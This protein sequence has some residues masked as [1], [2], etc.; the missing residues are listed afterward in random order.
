LSV[1]GN[2]DLA[3]GTLLAEIN[4]V[5]QGTTYDWLPVNGVVTIGPNSKLTLIFGAAAGNG[6]AYDVV[7]AGILSGTFALNNISFSNT[8]SGNVTGITV[9]YPGGTIV[10]ITIASPLPIELV[11]FQAI[12]EGEQVRLTWQTASEINNEGF[13]VERSLDIIGWEEIGFV[14]GKG[15]TTAVQNYSFLDEKPATS[16][17]YYRLRQ[18]DFDGKE[19]LSKIVSIDL[20]HLQ[21]L[22]IQVFPNP[23]KA[24]GELTLFLPDV[25]RAVLQG[26][27]GSEEMMVQLFSPAGQLVRSVMLENGYNSLTTNGLSTGVHTLRVGRVFEKIVIIE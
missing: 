4:G 25:S 3:N 16:L 26:M 18:I 22:S 17:N 27:T 2:I 12:T 21:D 8:G 15:T 6:A 10:R 13:H 20:T 9:T 5:G 7:T 19:E 23:A 24:G 1:I 11:D 14:A